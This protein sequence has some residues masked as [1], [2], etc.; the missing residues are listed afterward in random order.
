MRPSAAARTMRDTITVR[1]Q[2]SVDGYGQPTF[3]DTPSVA[4]RVTRSATRGVT[5]EGE[6]FTVTTR[7]L[8]LH[9]VKVGDALVIQGI[10]RPVRAVR[11]ACGTR[12]GATLYEAHL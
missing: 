1:S 3:T 5:P 10:E 4:A 12:G 9:P 7:V 8:T 2:A 6:E 11:S